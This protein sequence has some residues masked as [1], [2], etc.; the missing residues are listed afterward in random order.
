MTGRGQIRAVTINTMIVYSTGGKTIG[1]SDYKNN[2]TICQNGIPI[3]PSEVRTCIKSD[4]S[5]PNPIISYRIFIIES[6]GG[7]TNKN[8]TLYKAAIM[9]S[10]YGCEV[11]LEGWDVLY[12]SFECYIAIFISYIAN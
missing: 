10:S 2:L 4:Y 9:R 8:K 11:H 6:P 12:S 1:I 3:P 5:I 7:E